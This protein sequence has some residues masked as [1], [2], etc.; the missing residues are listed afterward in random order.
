MAQL[1]PSHPLDPNDAVPLYLQVQRAVEQEM[2]TG[3][4]PP[5]AA[6]PSEA[7]LSARYGVSRA[8]V[9]Q[10]MQRLT[11]RG[12]VYRHVGRGSFALAPK[13]VVR[14]DRYVSFSEELEARGHVPGSRL[15]GLSVVAADDLV[16]QNLALPP[17][18]DVVRLIRL[19]LADWLPVAYSRSH[20]RRDLVPG[21][22]RD[23]LSSPAFSLHRHLRQRFG[24]QW[25]ES[26]STLRPALLGDEAAPH[27][28]QSVG[29]PVFE[30]H[31]LN[32]VAGGGVAEFS[33]DFYRGDRMV[34]ELRTAASPPSGV[35]P[36]ALSRVVTN[37]P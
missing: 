5:P 32:F 20:I 26:Y 14:L 34:V 2:R 9:R 1:A 11:E 6:L 17:G 13:P 24:I 7:D 33:H 3:A 18:A 4:W 30:M 12:L 8:T 35:P 27:L 31:T 23:D 36:S 22:E 28:E 25:G 37:Q 15:L 21:I 16:A 29:T 10:A 19:R